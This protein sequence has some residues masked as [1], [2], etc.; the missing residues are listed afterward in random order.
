MNVLVLAPHAYYIDRGTPID[1]DILLRALSRRGA[2]V[3]VVVFSEGQDRTYPNVTLHR[4]GGRRGANPVRPGFS[5]RKLW[6]DVKLFFKTWGLLRRGRYDVV[7][8]GEESVFFAMIFRRLYG[9]PYIYDMDS[10]IA[11]QMVEQMPA[12]RP[13][14][15]IFDWCEARAIRGSIAAAPVCN[16]LADL[17]RRRG[18]PHVVTLHDIS[19]MT[20][21]DFRNEG[22]VRG[23]LGLDGL[24][25]MYVGNLQVYQGLDLLLES[26][27]LA[28]ARGADL[29]LV[30]AGG[31]E[32]HIRKY[33]EMAG[34]LGCAARTHF[35]GPWPVQ[36]LG[37][38]LGEADILAAPRIKGINTPM[39]VFPYLHSGKAVVVTDLPT[40]TQVLDDSVALL[41]PAEPQGFA[42]AIVRLA[43]DEALRR[44]LG[45]AGRRFVEANHTFPAHVRRV[46][47]LYDHVMRAR[48]PAAAAET[49]ASALG[50]GGTG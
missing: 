27:G 11:Q 41:A 7:H 14:A 5:L 49:S 40:H 44:K 28:L 35:I 13:L 30:V 2:K 33:R 12:L 38:L 31:T 10:S 42:E 22:E 34:R 50:N 3:D 23:R 17:A 19:Q 16:A 18:A 32:P 6:C 29:D 47:A 1:V 43:G 48:R 9:V 36:R 25:M 24:V 20:P 26:F 4:I 21:E 45:S 37:A 8:A 15:G 46:E 39:K